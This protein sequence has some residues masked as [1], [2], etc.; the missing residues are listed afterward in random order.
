MRKG[1]IFDHNKCVNC[2]ACKAACIL[3][4]GWKVQPR[5]IFTYNSEAEP[6]LSLI[7]L[8]LACNH[9]ESAICMEGC[10]ASAYSRESVTGA[11][12]IDDVKCIGCRYCQ[13]NCP[14]DAPRFDPENKIINKCNL[15]YSRLIDGHQPAC[16][17]ACPTGALGFGILSELKSDVFYSWFP[18]KNL[19]PAIE[20]SS[21]L[22]DIPLKI[23]PDR[24]PVREDLKKVDATKNISGELSLIAFSFLTTLSVSIII[25][26]LVKGVFP[27]RMIL[28]PVLILAGA[29]SLF[30][31]GN[32]LR[33]WRSVINVRNSPLSREIVLYI[34]YTV[35]SVIAGF[36]HLP[37]LLIAASLTGL[38]LLLQ[39]DNVYY[40]ANRN[41]SVF[42]HSGQTF[43]SALFIVSFLSGMLLSFVLIALV[44]L[45]SSVYI[46]SVN[47]TNHISGIRF[48][49][50][51]LLLVSGA[52]MV[53]QIS[54][55]D[56]FIISLFLTGELFDRVMFYIDFD[57]LN[58][59][60]L[61]SKTLN[62]EKDEKKR[63]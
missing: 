15:C 56:L 57:P 48:L 38:I 20:F 12:I 53:S 10:P 11:I 33:A 21:S 46:L 54:Y 55:H 26:S 50:I 60:T 25:T 6:L 5:N 52:S 28:I 29:I 47:K 61:I 13:W 14:Y 7:N 49:R 58:I 62:S 35:V 51:A 45:A 8:S 4:N 9:C 59:N 3:E 18:D 44:K 43:M 19:N 41:K 24:I 27:E 34:I 22:N 37:G 2:N 30:H 40:Y 16:S 1:F 36:F 39:I 32:R 17:A 31:L 42:L 63:G 23:I